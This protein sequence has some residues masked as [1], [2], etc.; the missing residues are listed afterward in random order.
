MYDE[1]RILRHD[2]WRMG[3]IWPFILV[4]SCRFSHFGHRVLL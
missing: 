4:V 3:R 1:L 2:E